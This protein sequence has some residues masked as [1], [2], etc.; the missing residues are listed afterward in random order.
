MKDRTWI[1]AG[2][3][4]LFSPRGARKSIVFASGRSLWATW[5]RASKKLH[6]NRR[7]GGGAWQKI[8]GDAVKEWQ[9]GGRYGKHARLDNSRASGLR[10]IASE[11][12]HAKKTEFESNQGWEI[13]SQQRAEPDPHYNTPKVSPKS[14]AELRISP[15][16]ACD[17]G[18][19]HF[20]YTSC[21]GEVGKS[22]LPP[23]VTRSFLPR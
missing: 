15:S 9:T 13:D 14:A 23:K 21:R 18:Y 6:R 2:Q 16:S 8:S 4:L 12:A 19:I 17:D 5:R 3:K 10:S 22:T 7:I 20:K 1:K 11:T